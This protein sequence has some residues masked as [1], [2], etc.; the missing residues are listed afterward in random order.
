MLCMCTVYVYMIMCGVKLCLGQF[1]PYHFFIIL[2]W[3]KPCGAQVSLAN[4]NQTGTLEQEQ[5]IVDFRND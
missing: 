5:M 4:L 3:G 1:P 2:L